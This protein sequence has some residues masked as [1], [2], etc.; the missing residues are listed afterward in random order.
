MTLQY[1][2]IRVLAVIVLT[3]LLISFPAAAGDHTVAPSGAEFSSIKDAIDWSIG[4]DT[5]R[6]ESGTYTENLK[7]D[8]KLTLIGVDTGSGAP[9]IA[10]SKTGN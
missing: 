1:S 6:V 2:C 7:L 5:I 3:C 8:K 4:G 9:V 10:P